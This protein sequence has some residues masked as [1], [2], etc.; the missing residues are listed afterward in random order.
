MF[1]IYGKLKGNAKNQLTLAIIILTFAKNKCI[2]QFMP[3]I[4]S[5]VSKKFKNR[6]L[7]F[8]ANSDGS[9]KTVSQLI[10]VSVIEYIDR[11]SGTEMEPCNIK[12]NQPPATMES[13]TAQGFKFPEA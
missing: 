5:E 9:I 10:R 4:N 7:D 12:P 11:R 8:L 2:L 3:W 13:D 1:P 6:L